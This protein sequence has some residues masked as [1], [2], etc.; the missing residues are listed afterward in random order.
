VLASPL[1]G[2][3]RAGPYQ[4]E[5]PRFRSGVL[6]WQMGKSISPVGICLP[7]DAVAATGSAPAD[8]PTDEEQFLIMLRMHPINVGL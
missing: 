1:V 3:L 8:S 6:G 2:P 7:P 5:P 4:G